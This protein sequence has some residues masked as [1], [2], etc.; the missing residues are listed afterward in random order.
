LYR[1][2]NEFKLGYQPRINIIKD[3]NGNVIEAPQSVPNR[4]KNFFNQVLNVHGVHDVRQM[5]IHM[6]E[7]M[8]PEHSLVKVEITIGKLKSYKSLDTDQILAKLIKVGGETLCSEIQKLVLYGI[9]R[10]C[11]SIGRNLLLYQFIKRVI[12]LIVIII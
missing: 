5:D 2:I 7:P 3:E 9:R 1:G 6:P 8:V 12:R 10:N 11:H 4:W